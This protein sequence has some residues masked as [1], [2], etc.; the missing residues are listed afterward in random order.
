MILWNIIWNYFLVGRF[1]WNQVKM[2]IIYCHCHY[3]KWNR[4]ADTRNVI[5]VQLLYRL[6]QFSTRQS[7]FLQ[8]RDLGFNCWYFH[9]AF[10]SMINK[11]I[12]RIFNIILIF[13]NNNLII[14]KQNSVFKSMTINFYFSLYFLFP[15]PSEI[16]NYK[17][18]NMGT[19]YILASLL[20]VSIS[21][22]KEL[23]HPVDT[24]CAMKSLFKQSR[25]E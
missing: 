11:R 5:I 18:N 13:V 17:V 22:N 20:V 3:H 2:T 23:Y 7:S 4:I 21:C 24:F 8:Q 10:R 19:D 9:A 25:R 14:S 15:P 12:N 1:V 6:L 16:L